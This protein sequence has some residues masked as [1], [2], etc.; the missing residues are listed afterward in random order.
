[1][2]EAQSPVQLCYFLLGCLLAVSFDLGEQLLQLV[3]L[4]LEQ[5]FLPLGAGQTVPERLVL[6][7]QGGDAVSEFSLFPMLPGM[8]VLELFPVSKQV[9]PLQIGEC[10]LLFV[11]SEFLLELLP[12]F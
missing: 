9:L 12:F 3:G 2:G 1:L 4:G 8:L 6:F 11:E 10:S 7:L 5:L